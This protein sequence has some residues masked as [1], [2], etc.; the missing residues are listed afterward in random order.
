[1]ANSIEVLSRILAGPAIP[2]VPIFDT[3][4]MLTE[5]ST[6]ARQNWDKSAEV[7]STEFLCQVGES[8]IK[9]V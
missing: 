8:V 2:T 9:H 1:M 3:F 4:V 5:D 6:D 7:S